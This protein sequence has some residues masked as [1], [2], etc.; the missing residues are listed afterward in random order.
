[1]KNDY[2]AAHLRLQAFAQAGGQLQGD[3]PLAQFSR[4]REESHGETGHT[5]VHYRAQG[6]VRTGGE[7]AGQI[8]LALSA[9]V[10]LPL[11]CQRCL[12]AADLTVAFEREFRFVA[13]EDVAEQEDEAA[14][15]DVLVLSR[16]FNLL[17]LVEDELLM[18]MPVV[19]K[20]AVCPQPVKLQ[21]SAPGFS[22]EVAENPN[23][24]AVLQQLK[25]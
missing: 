20:H 6:S 14:E 23:P 22:D 13:S 25:K 24:F 9:Q 16:D 4:L 11:I 21:V 7:G 5:K 8:W 12:G 19:P 15:E 1:M 10:Q 3:A 2:D 17:E 18:A